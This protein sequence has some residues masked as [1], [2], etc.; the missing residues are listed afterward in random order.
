MDL[1]G[2]ELEVILTNSKGRKKILKLKEL[3]PL[4][5]SSKDLKTK[6]GIIHGHHRV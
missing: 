4:P 1:A 2:E 3:L 5:F 6:G